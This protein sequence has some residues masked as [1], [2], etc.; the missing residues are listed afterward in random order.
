MSF[1][2]LTGLG[3]AVALAAL[4]GCATASG[5]QR[6]ASD[7]VQALIARAELCQHFA[8]EEP[9]DAARRAEIN[10]AFADNRCGRL[11]ADIH[12]LKIARPSDAARLEAALS[13]LRN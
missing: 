2:Y 5:G 8:D 9:Y 6:Q 4:A 3:L 12:A 10:K 13:G 7:P 1:R 11:D